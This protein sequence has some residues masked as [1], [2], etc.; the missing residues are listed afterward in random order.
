M[1]V[2]EA[3]I[4][5][6]YI[7]YIYFD[8][9]EVAKRYGQIEWIIDRWPLASCVSSRHFKTF[10]K[11]IILF[12]LTQMSNSVPSYIS[13]INIIS[14]CHLIWKNMFWSHQ[15]TFAIQIAY[16]HQKC[17]ANYVRGIRIEL[18]TFHKLSTW[19]YIKTCFL[20]MIE[21]GGASSIKVILP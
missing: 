7:C 2:D 9:C 20:S 14:C 16:A 10:D 1:F 8:Q 21:M 19:L 6:D 3:L 4:T 18:R 17:V 15:S 5:I 12:F 13:K 11:N